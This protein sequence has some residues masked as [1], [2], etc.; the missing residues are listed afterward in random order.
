MAKKLLKRQQRTGKLTAQEAARDQELRRKIEAEFPPLETPSVSAILSNPL[1]EAIAQEP[2]IGFAI[3]QRSGCI[4]N[5]VVTVSDWESRSAPG[6]SREV[7][8]RPWVAPE[9]RLICRKWVWRFQPRT[10]AA[11]IS[12]QTL[13]S[14][15]SSV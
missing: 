5:R 10:P 2:E 13:V 7:G 9:G 8:S 14:G 11:Q 12:E 6:N 4:A 15:R 1:K 3:G